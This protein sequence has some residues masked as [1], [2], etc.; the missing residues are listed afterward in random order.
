MN[1]TARTA[2]SIATASIT[3][4]TTPGP[5]R[6]SPPHLKGLR[7]PGTPSLSRVLS[8]SSG[9]AS[10]GPSRDHTACAMARG[11][12]LTARPDLGDS[13]RDV[14]ERLPNR[15]GGQGVVGS[16]PAVPTKKKA[17]TSGNTGQG[18]E[19]LRWRFEP[20]PENPVYVVRQ[21][22]SSSVCIVRRVQLRA[23]AFTEVAAAVKINDAGA[24]EE[25]IDQSVKVIGAIGDPRRR[26][27]MLALIVGQLGAEGVVAARCAPRRCGRAH[28]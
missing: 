16:N 3:V 24:A 2:G 23:V 8:S 13:V 21:P 28:Q 11:M 7:L 17:L 5:H 18:F 1:H 22:S 25:I 9:S 20:P 19:F 4:R 14:R 12:A 26:D 6:H 15:P 27:Q 10:R